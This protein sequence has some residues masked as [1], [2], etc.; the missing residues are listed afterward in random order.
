MNRLFKSIAAFVI[1]SFVCSMPSV[2]AAHEIVKMFAE[3]EVPQAVSYSVDHADAY[4]LTQKKA[5][6]LSKGK[7]ELFYES[8]TPLYCLFVDDSSVWIGVDNGVLVFQIKNKLKS[9]FKIDTT[10]A[11]CKIVTIFKNADQ[12]IYIGSDAY[13]LYAYRANDVP[14]KISTMFPINKGVAT[15]DSTIWVGTDVGLFRKRKNE[16][17]RY[18]EEG[19]SNFEIPDNIVQNLVVDNTGLLWVLMRNGLAVIE[20]VNSKD[21]KKSKSHSHEDEHGHIPSKEYLGRTQ[22]SIYDVHYYK[23]KGYLFATDM[24]MLYLPTY[25]NEE[26]VENFHHDGGEKVENKALLK[27]PDIAAINN[28]YGKILF[29]NDQGPNTYLIC[30]K[31]ICRLSKKMLLQMLS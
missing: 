28:E 21:L 2:Y 6:K 4:I 24:G 1:A 25:K 31:G 16:W 12:H 15:A 18:N 9:F 10:V 26:V 7:M 3:G 22:N 30:E 14:E 17:V 8:N 23:N 20:T 13:G 5:Y 19:V 11:T 29:I 27:M